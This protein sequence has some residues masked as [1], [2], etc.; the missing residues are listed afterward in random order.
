MP[1]LDDMKCKQCDEVF[2]K[3]DLILNEGYCY[4]CAAGRC[5]VCREPLTEEQL[6]NETIVCD[7]CTQKLEEAEEG[8][9][10]QLTEE[11][12]RALRAY[13]K[14]QAYMAEYNQRPRVKAARAERNKARAQRNSLMIKRLKEQGYIP[15][16][17][18]KEDSQ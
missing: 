12:R 2:S 6:N 7:T 3:D 14:H 1:T 17:N 4:N 8:D 5:S 15:N 10:D 18:G 13:Q 11:E 16:R 9:I